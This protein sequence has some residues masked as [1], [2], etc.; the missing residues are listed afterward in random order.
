MDHRLIISQK[1]SQQSILHTSFPYLIYKPSNLSQIYYNVTH[2]FHCIHKLPDLL[3]V[4]IYA[5]Q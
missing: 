3:C 1:N 2:L 4:G 5:I